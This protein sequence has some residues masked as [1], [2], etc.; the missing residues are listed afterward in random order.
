[1]QHNKTYRGVKLME[2]KTYL[3]IMTGQANNI[4][5]SLEEQSKEHLLSIQYLRPYFQP[6]HLLARR[7]KSQ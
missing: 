5:R 4:V 1:M 3:A 7:H 2:V 6:D